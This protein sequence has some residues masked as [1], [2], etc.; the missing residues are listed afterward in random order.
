[1]LEKL[2]VVMYQGNDQ[3]PNM[4]QNT[5][6]YYIILKPVMT[7]CFTVRFCSFVQHI[8]SLHCFSFFHVCS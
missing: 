3:E 1:M 5:D 2:I 6:R 7:V 8:I 4:P